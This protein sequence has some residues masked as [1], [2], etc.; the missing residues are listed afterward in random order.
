MAD[1]EEEVWEGF[2]RVRAWE[3]QGGAGVGEDAVPPQSPFS[4]TR[5]GARPPLCLLTPTQPL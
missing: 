4:I 5:Q 2:L 1:L 3:L